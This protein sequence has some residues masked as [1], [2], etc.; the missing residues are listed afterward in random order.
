M[1][2]VKPDRSRIKEVI[3]R[4]H[5]MSKVFCVHSVSVDGYISG[6]DPSDSGGGF[7]RGLGDS[8]RLFDWYRYGDTPSRCPSDTG[9]P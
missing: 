4:S 2:I 6:L 8:P 5:V 7:G 9:L 3:E 1:A